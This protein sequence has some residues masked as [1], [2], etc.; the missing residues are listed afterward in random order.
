[1][2]PI[3][4]LFLILI[5]PVVQAQVNAYAAIDSIRS[6]TIYISASQSEVYDTFRSGDQV[7]IMQ[8]Q[9]DVIGSNNQNNTSFGNLSSLSSAGF[10]E[11][12]YVYSVI[13]TAGIVSRLMINS[14]LSKTFNTGPNSSVQAISFRLPASGNYTTT[15]DIK[16]L[17][18]NG[19]YG[20]VVAI[21]VN[22]TLT[23]NHNISADTAGFRGGILN[24]GNAGSCE[25]TKY[26]IA[27]N[28][29]NANK[30]E[31]IY[32][33]T[34]VLFKAG[35]AKILNGGG[36][37]NSHNGGGGGGSNFKGGGDGGKGFGCSST[38]ANGIGGIALGTYVTPD[39]V[40]MGGG[41]GAGEG[42]NNFNTAGGNGGGIV[43]I[44]ASQIQT[45]GTG[46]AVRIS[47]NG[48]TASDIGNDGAGGG[49][50]GGSIVFSVSN[51]NAVSTK[52]LQIAA[53]GGLGGNVS[54]A[55]AHGGGG[56]G[57]Q[58]TI[59]FNTTRPSTNITVNTL[60][61]LGGRNYSG[62][63]FAANAAGADNE[64]ISNGSYVILPVSLVYF[65][66]AGKNNS[67]DLQWKAQN[68]IALN[69]YEVER[70]ADA[71]SYKNISSVIVNDGNNGLYTFTDMQPLP[72]TGYYRLK[73][74]DNDGGYVY[75]NLVSIKSK[76]PDPFK[77]VVYPNPS[78]SRTILKVTSSINTIARM[79]LINLNGNILTSWYINLKKGENTVPVN[80][81]MLS[82]GQ[83]RIS[84][85][86]NNVT[87]VAGVTVQK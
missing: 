80:T 24:A 14:P 55:S 42:N 47:A 77:V 43:I 52:P 71:I 2:K 69:R 7:I 21:R 50:S 44:K 35:R 16:A 12:A 74:I 79:R 11:V 64:G 13:R 4:T 62:G 37:G 73:I 27:E 10:Y 66:G 65:K 17:P 82:N 45:T 49:G 29:L 9:D 41:G 48:E 76:A 20:G 81:A 78:S 38:P 51:W 18:W 25:S 30:G 70:S 8:M 53:N 31:G 46:S 54:D 28:E 86:T 23:L 75:S 85:T 72:A 32:K 40:F 84:I 6:T 57:S 60:I 61:G 36:G 58:G 56:G 87:M 59:Q 19:S 3:Y 39:R 15:S 22:G 67:V 33:A 63:T 1:V 68:E 26:I 83:Y 34:D 5:P